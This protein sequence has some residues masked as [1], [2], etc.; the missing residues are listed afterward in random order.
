MTSPD[1]SILDALVTRWA[2][3]R[4]SL[5]VSVTAALLSAWDGIDVYDAAAV[6]RFAQAAAA[7]SWA[8]QQQAAAGS[9]AYLRQVL[10]VLGVQLPRGRLGVLT[11]PVRAGVD[12]LAVYSRPA[13][14]LRYLLSQKTPRDAASA[15]ARRRLRT[16]AEMDL[17]LAARQVEPQVL[18]ASDRVLGYR[19]VLRPE[20]AKGGSCGLCVAAS[21]RLYRVDRLKPIHDGCNCGT[22]PVTRTEDPGAGLNGADLRALYKAAGSTQAKALR[23]V[24]VQVLEHGELGPVL[25]DARHDNRGPGDVAA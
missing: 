14:T 10:G 5:A 18:S 11:G 16:L 4:E 13:A 8:G 17:S 19:R 6:T 25:T 2:Q 22:L 9:E 20:M 1:P 15:Q 23:R 21:D 7:L 12:V 3:T 24:R